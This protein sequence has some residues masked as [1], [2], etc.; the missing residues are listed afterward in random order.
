MPSSRLD[1]ASS[2]LPINNR[3]PLIEPAPPQVRRVPPESNRLQEEPRGQLWD[4]HPQEPQVWKAHGWSG[5]YDSLDNEQADEA[6]LLIN[7]MPS[8]ILRPGPVFL[9]P[10]RET[11]NRA[12]T[13]PRLG[14]TTHALQWIGEAKL[15][16]YTAQEV[17][18]FAISEGEIYS[19]DTSFG[20][21]TKLVTAANLA[22]AGITL[23]ASVACQAVPFNGTLAI[24][25]ASG[26]PFTWS[27]ASGAGGLVKLTN[28]PTN[29]L[30]I[31]VYYAKLFFLLIDSTIY[32][33]EELQANTGYVAGG[34]NNAWKLNQTTEERVTAILGTNEALYF[35]RYQGVGAIRGAVSST[36][37]TDGVIDGVH[38]GSGPTAPPGFA[39]YAGTLFWMDWKGQVFAARGGGEAQNLSLQLPRV[40]GLSSKWDVGSY[41]SNPPWNVGESII[42]LATPQMMVVDKTNSR[43]YVEYFYN[44]AGA[45]RVVHVY[46][47]SSLKLLS[48]WR[49]GFANGHATSTL[50]SPYRFASMG[51]RS[52]TADL[53]VYVDDAGYVFQ[54]QV[55]GWSNRPPTAD[56]TEAGVGTAITGT[57]LG[58]KH[59]DNHNTEYAFQFIDVVYEQLDANVVIAGYLTPHNPRSDLGQASQSSAPTEAND[60]Q[61]RRLRFGLG[62]NARGRWLRP[63]IQVTGRANTVGGEG[64]EMILGY[65]VTGIPISKSP[66]MR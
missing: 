39:Y 47:T 61:E 5:M 58:P 11:L 64:P 65:S 2:R 45:G 9:R 59:G 31:T 30:D 66:A 19:V 38:Q 43:L 12:A 18:L 16:G 50:P 35:G 46:D 17:G 8:D 20:T 27:G 42:G 21:V 62:A 6:T 48:I 1:G 3:G 54:Q 60:P 36:F 13:A 29:A 23:S 7:L 34:Y 22:T 32:W 51:R 52:N 28:A 37:Q 53:Y 24:A 26:A 33:S 44:S 4:Y 57:L 15:T 55:G 63:Y 40:H 56:Y 49:L 10:G 41:V 25:P 14:V